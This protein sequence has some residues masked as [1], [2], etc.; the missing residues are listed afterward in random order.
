[1]AAP[2][3]VRPPPHLALAI[4]LS[5]A[6]ARLPAAE[7]A[8]EPIFGTP[9]AELLE[10][11]AASWGAVPIFFPPEPPPFAS[12]EQ[13]LRASGGSGYGALR[14]P[15]ELADYIGEPFYPALGTRLVMRDLGVWSRRQLEGYR[16]NR[17][18]LLRELRAELQ[19]T[20]DLTGEARRERLAA[21][22]REQTPK[23][24]ALEKRAEQLRGSLT[25]LDYRWGAMRTSLDVLGSDRLNPESAEEIADVMRA[26]AYYEGGLLPAQRRFLREIAL[27]LPLAAHTLQDSVNA[28]PE[29]F[30]SPGLARVRWPEDLPDELRKQIKDY[31]AQRAVLKKRLYD[32]VFKADRTWFAV[33][34]AVQLHYTLGAQA[35]ELEWLET[36]AEEIRRGFARLPP[37]GRRSGCPPELAQRLAAALESRRTLCAGTAD[38]LEAIRRRE[39]LLE[40]SY[41]LEPMG[42]QYTV[43][44]RDRALLPA[45]S[46][47]KVRAK[48]VEKE[49]AA[50]AAAHR[51]AFVTLERE[52]ASIAVSLGRALLTD[53]PREI[54]LSLI[55]AT[56]EAFEQEPDGP[57][58]AYRAAVFE[59]GLSPEQRRLLLDAAVRQ[60]Q[61]PLPRGEY[62]PQD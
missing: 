6:V 40:I 57:Y 32:V 12:L 39:S 23:I 28:Q 34:R 43:R 46:E 9:P 1:M 56:R 49:I 3:T 16:A 27:E 36:L 5:G 26:A 62:Q 45:S 51:Q 55:A 11:R 44:P 17:T 19:R 2:F 24:V 38:A 8:E 13:S 7:P 33:L 50:I 31:Q 14:A 53:E 52:R 58:H 37:A 42:I 48:A 54:E 30:F 29:E 59:P 25:K 20:R 21:F 35:G 41:A 4:C 18:M 22:A 61:P 15:P 47:A 60:L 10:A